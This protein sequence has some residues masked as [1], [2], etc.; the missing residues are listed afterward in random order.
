MLGPLYRVELSTAGR[1]AACV[2]FTSSRER[3]AVLRAALAEMSPDANT[4]ECV[5]H[6]VY[7]K[8]FALAEECEELPQVARVF[9]E[10]LMLGEGAIDGRCKLHRLFCGLVENMSGF[11]SCDG[12]HCV[13]ASLYNHKDRK[14][15]DRL[16][17]PPSPLPPSPANNLPARPLPHPPISNPPSLF[18]R[19][20]Q[21]INGGDT[22]STGARSRQTSTW[23]SYTRGQSTSYGNTLDEDPSAKVSFHLAP[24]R[25][26]GIH[27]HAP[28]AG[29][30]RRGASLL[31]LLR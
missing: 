4:A 25:H 27:Q 21:S 15:A 8:M 6:C 2:V 28:I 13:S 16:P 10:L 9:E 1:G 31:G 14:S 3:A 12:A 20:V 22:P 17:A 30:P 26:A 11:T 29:R 24:S 7:T 23:T 19:I 18:E 5:H